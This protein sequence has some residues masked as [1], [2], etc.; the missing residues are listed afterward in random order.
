MDISYIHFLKF[1]GIIKLCRIGNVRLP[2]YLGAHLEKVILRGDILYYQMAV[3][4]ILG[5][6]SHLSNC[7]TPDSFNSKEYNCE[8]RDKL[9]SHQSKG[10][11]AS[12]STCTFCSR[13]GMKLT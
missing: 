5:F 3:V 7:P 4:M 13:R 10:K 11:I 9:W 1:L 6:M 12:T 8:L 2:Y